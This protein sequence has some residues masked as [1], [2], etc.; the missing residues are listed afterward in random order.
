MIRASLFLTA[1]LA[2]AA[3]A[4]AN[5]EAWLAKVGRAEAAFEAECAAL[6]ERA[7]PEGRVWLRLGP[8]GV[9][10]APQDARAAEAA[11]FWAEA[12]LGARRAAAELY[13][14]AAGAALKAAPVMIETGPGGAVAVHDGKTLSTGDPC[15]AMRRAV[16]AMGGAAGDPFA[17]ARGAAEDQRRT[18]LA[19][20][21]GA[22]IPLAGPPPEG[23]VARGPDGVA[24]EIVTEGDETALVLT[25]GAD[26][27]PGEG[28]ALI[29]A[30]GDRFRPV[31]EIPL[32]V[33]PAPPP[34][35]PAGGGAL[36]LGE[37]RAGDLA[38]G[39]AHVFSF[40]MSEA[41]RVVFASGDAGD[42]R[43]ELTTETGDVIAKDD[44]SGQGYGFRLSAE[45]PAGRYV[46]NLSHCCGGGGRYVVSTASE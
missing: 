8:E 31:A 6:A 1:L 29:Y 19:I 43:A 21:G 28:A 46:L 34:P 4:R 40:E 38:A 36:S 18:P 17:A 9:E 33:L 26:A 14:Q 23:S 35:K 3:P 39:D 41:G 7:P 37:R 22:R 30:P 20:G 10:I 44:D 12:A 27:R 13:G 11:A 24:A 15:D 45:L 42:F 25:A 32:L 2:A 16:A 5:L